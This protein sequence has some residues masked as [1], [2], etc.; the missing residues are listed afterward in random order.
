MRHILSYIRED[1]WRTRMP[2]VKVDAKE[3]SAWDRVHARSAWFKNESSEGKIAFDPAAR[4]QRRVLWLNSE[5][6]RAV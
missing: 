2:E 3:M 4:G 5:R 6:R 1:L